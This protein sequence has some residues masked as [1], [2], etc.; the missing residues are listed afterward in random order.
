MN[1]TRQRGRR[2]RNGRR[3]QT[4]L[5]LLVATSIIAITLVP[6][7]RMMR[8]SVRV[9]R[10]VEAGTAMS[11]ICVDRL[12]QYLALSCG[13]WQNVNVT[14][15]CAAQGYPQ[16]KWQVFA[17]DGAVFGGTPNRLMVIYSSVW[18]DRNN[19]N[20]WE[21]SSEPRVQFATKLAHVVAYEHEAAG[22]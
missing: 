16:L 21:S 3:G 4:L 11:T 14:G 22:S 5:E 7:L 6:A 19:N 8:D 13:S 15:D 10:R 9:G 1:G 20:L 12:E 2:R 17:N 18:E